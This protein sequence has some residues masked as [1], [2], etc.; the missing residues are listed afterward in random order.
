MGICKKIYQ[1]MQ[2]SPACKHQRK[3][4]DRF[5]TKKYKRVV[6][7]ASKKQTYVLLGKKVCKAY[8]K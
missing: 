1:E 4:L 8:I 6:E 5:W 2:E 3:D 7:K